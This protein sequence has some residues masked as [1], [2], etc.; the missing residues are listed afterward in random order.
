MA[1]D[2]T[3]PDNCNKVR[4]LIGDTDSDDPM[5]KDTEI[6]YCITVENSDLF[7]AAARCCETVASRFARD[8]DYRFSTL[9]Q[10]AGDAFDHYMALA[11]RLRKSDQSVFDGIG[12]QMSAVLTDRINNSGGPEIFWIGQHDNPSVPINPGV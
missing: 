3:L 1:Y 8:V 6:E 4:F 7:F 11:E 10:N 5:L 2:E 9:W 12:L